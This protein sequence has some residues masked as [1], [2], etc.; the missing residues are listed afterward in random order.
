[1]TSSTWLRTLAVLLALFAA[2]HT[3]GTAAPHVTRGPQEAA[4][5]DAMQSF[6]F[7]IMGFERT[8]WDFYRGFAL[9]ISVLMFALMVMAWQIGAIS[10]R[11]GRAALPLV[12]TLQLACVGLLVVGWFFFFGAPIVFSAGAVVLSTIAAITT[13]RQPVAR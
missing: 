2:G 12:I 7:P 9:T 13:A 10:K 4:L 11:I 1:M 8:Y 6:R 3:L 5:F